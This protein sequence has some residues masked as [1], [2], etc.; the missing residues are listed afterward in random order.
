VPPTSATA[1]SVIPESRYEASSQLAPVWSDDGGA[2]F[3][4]RGFVI[5]TGDLARWSAG[6]SSPSVLAGADALSGTFP[7]ADLQTQ[8]SGT[9]YVSCRGAQHFDAIN[10]GRLAVTSHCRSQVV[11]VQPGGVRILV[12]DGNVEDTA[13]ENILLLDVTQDQQDPDRLVGTFT[14]HFQLNAGGE[15]QVVACSTPE[16]CATY[17]SGYEAGPTW[18]PDGRRVAFRFEP[19][20]S[21]IT[22]TQISVADVGGSRTI[23]L[24][25]APEADDASI[26]TT[27]AWSPGGDWLAFVR[28]Q[29]IDNADGVA[30]GSGPGDV[31]AVRTD[32]VGVQE[33]IRLT[34][35]ALVGGRFYWRASGVLLPKPPMQ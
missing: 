4:Q 8:Q 16:A 27:L 11:A 7:I 13:S 23:S 6:E 15:G 24:L 19:A 33:P 25:V 3:F 28:G 20:E 14:D 12:I 32:G 34:R 21:S 30:V 29:R 5:N 35:N 1:L 22:S 10:A 2:I 18:D 9:P 26:I 31:Y 17:E